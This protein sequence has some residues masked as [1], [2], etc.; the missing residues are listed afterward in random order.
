MEIEQR[1]TFMVSRKHE[2]SLKRFEALIKE[3]VPSSVLIYQNGNI[4]FS[5]EN[6]SGLFQPED[7]DRKIL[8][9]LKALKL[10][11]KEEIKINQP[12]TETSVCYKFD[13]IQEPLLKDTCLLLLNT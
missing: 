1:L 11:S 5:N 8:D 4:V 9:G 2:I 10:S 6:C 12:T 7:D 13:D 3:M